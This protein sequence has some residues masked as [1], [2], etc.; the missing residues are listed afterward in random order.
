MSWLSPVQW[1]K[2]TWS[3]V[4]GAGEEEGEGGM[5]EDEDSFRQREEEEEKSQR[6]RG[7]KKLP[8]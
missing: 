8:V 4:R 2:W 3:A 5:K 6:Y 1:A 7:T